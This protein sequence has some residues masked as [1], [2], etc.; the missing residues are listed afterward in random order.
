M[1]R[2]WYGK[3]IL[4]RV[5]VVEGFQAGTHLDCLGVT[6]FLEDGQCLVPGRARCRE[7]AGVV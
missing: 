2:V 7:M 1:Y 6:E 4:V 5:V 3:G